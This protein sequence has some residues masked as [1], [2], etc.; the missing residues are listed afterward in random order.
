[1]LNHQLAPRVFH[2]IVNML[3]SR[4]SMKTGARVAGVHATVLVFTNLI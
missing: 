1:M 2:P 3:Y 4:K